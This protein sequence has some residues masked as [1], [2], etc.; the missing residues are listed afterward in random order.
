[1]ARP[2]TKTA[3]YSFSLTAHQDEALKKLMKDDLTDNVGDYIGRLIADAYRA[4][5]WK[6]DTKEDEIDP[7]DIPY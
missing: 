4:R 1:M 5:T 7:R 2:K 3:R 6:T